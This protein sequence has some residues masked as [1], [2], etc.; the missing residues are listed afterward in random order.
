MWNLKYGP[1]E[2]VYR[3]ENKLMDREQ[4]CGW[5]GGVGRSGMDRG[6]E[7][8][9]CKLLHLKCKNNEIL[10]YGTRN[11]IQCFGN[12][13]QWRKIVWGKGCICMYHWI[14]LQ[15]SRN[16]YNIANQLYFN[17]KEKATIS[18]LI[19]SKWSLKMVTIGKEGFY[20]MMKGSIQEEYITIIN[21][22]APNIQTP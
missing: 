3:T 8:G 20:L 13:I 1:N 2:P 12:Y 19:S 5:Q 14:T 11:Y 18:V 22:Y 9:R 15:Y 21:I 6:L 7:V 4:I 10:L 17:L 16:W